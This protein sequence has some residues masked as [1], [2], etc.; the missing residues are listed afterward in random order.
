MSMLSGLFKGQWNNDSKTE[1]EDPRC[2]GHRHDLVLG[3]IIANEMD[4]QYQNGQN[5]LQ[6]AAP[7]DKPH[8]DT[9]VFFAA[10]M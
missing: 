1:S 8:N 2:K 6:Y 3:S 10:G 4:F 7:E 9:V 5:Y